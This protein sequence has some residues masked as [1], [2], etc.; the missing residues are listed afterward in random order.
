MSKYPNERT[1]KSYLKKL[2]LYNANEIQ[3]AWKQVY[4]DQSQEKMKHDD[5]ELTI[6]HALVTDLMDEV[7]I[8]ENERC[9]K[10]KEA[11]D[12]IEAIKTKQP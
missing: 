1:A 8:D 4:Y 12:K 11:L 6:L 7:F 5:A 9:V 2:G 3:Y 10:I